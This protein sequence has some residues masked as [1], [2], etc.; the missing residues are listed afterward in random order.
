[1]KETEL[2]PFCKDCIYKGTEY[3]SSGYGMPER[4]REYCILEAQNKPCA[5][6]T[7]NEVERA[8]DKTDLG[9]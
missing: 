9:S 2:P 7:E 1:M 5:K 8:F 4:S 3:S 6:E